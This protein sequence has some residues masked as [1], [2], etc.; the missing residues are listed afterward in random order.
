MP[1]DVSQSQI[2]VPSRSIASPMNPPPGQTITAA[3][4]FLPFAGNTVIVGC[5]TLVIQVQGLPATNSFVSTVTEDSGSGGG[6]ASGAFP[7]Q[8]GICTSGAGGCHTA[9]L[10]L[11]PP[12][13]STP[14]IA[15]L[16]RFI[17]M[18]SGNHVVG[19]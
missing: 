11:R 8:I 2:S 15:R 7:G 17:A 6:N 18:S 13:T 16:K 14:Q 5:E 12:N 3:P 1:F 10:T 9:A 4:V 19:E